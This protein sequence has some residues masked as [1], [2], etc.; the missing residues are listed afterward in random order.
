[1]LVSLAE[2]FRVPVVATNGVRFASQA[3][4]PLHDVLTCIRE[5]TTLPRQGGGWSP[6][7]SATSSRRRRWPGSSTICRTP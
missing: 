2:A 5:H 6:M 4:R 7:P 1:M 3:E